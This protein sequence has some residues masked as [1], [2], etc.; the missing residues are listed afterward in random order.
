MVGVAE[1]VL[2]VPLPAV[3]REGT[4]QYLWKEA[5]SGPVAQVVR[6]GRNNLTHVEVVDGLV[7][8]ETIFLAPPPGAELPEFAQAEDAA[9]AMF[10]SADVSRADAAM[11]RQQQRR[12]QVT[13]LLENPTEFLGRLREFLLV[14]LP[15]YG[16]ELED[17]NNWMRLLSDPSFQDEADLVLG[18]APTLLEAWQIFKDN[19]GQLSAPGGTNRPAGA[20]RGGPGGRGRGRGGR[21]RGGERGR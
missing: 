18:T 4:V 14:E 8:G 11:F 13:A 20:G 5:T 19:G 10:S 1:D 2:T 7:E 16:N 3:L 21:G 12:Q 9:D 15:N 17:E 6:V